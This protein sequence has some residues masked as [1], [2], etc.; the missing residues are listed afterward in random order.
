MLCGV[1]T[2]L[3]RIGLYSHNSPVIW[4]IPFAFQLVPVHVGRDHGTVLGLLA[5]PESPRWLA[6]G[7]HGP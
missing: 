2:V 7:P 1:I 3:V 6:S 5:V 4:R